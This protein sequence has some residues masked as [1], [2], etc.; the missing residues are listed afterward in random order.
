MPRVRCHRVQSERTRR[1]AAQLADGSPQHPFKPA[2]RNDSGFA[3]HRHAILARTRPPTQTATG[4]LDFR[5]SGRT[6]VRAGRRG[7][8]IS[9]RAVGIAIGALADRDAAMPASR[10][11]HSGAA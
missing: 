9:V 2:R 7:E 11:L 6:C 10:N 3:H 5:G 8:M 1:L 4:P